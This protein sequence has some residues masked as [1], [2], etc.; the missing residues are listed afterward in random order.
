[1]KTAEKSSREYKNYTVYTSNLVREMYNN[2]AAGKRLINVRKQFIME[3][4]S[5]FP[6]MTT[7][8]ALLEMDRKWKRS[9]CEQHSALAFKGSKHAD[10]S[11][12]YSDGQWAKGIQG[13]CGPYILYGLCD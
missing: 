12:E 9:V 1:M 3:R 7:T 5:S 8:N 11:S 6:C 10:V 13:I 2:I 4:L